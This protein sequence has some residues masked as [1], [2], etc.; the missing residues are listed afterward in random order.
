MASAL[1]GRIVN[2]NTASLADMC[3]VHYYVR[4]IVLLKALDYKVTKKCRVMLNS[5]LG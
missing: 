4:K 1:L 3:L 2:D 5:K